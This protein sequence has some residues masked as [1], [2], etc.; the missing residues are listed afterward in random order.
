MKSDGS[1]SNG[2]D[3]EIARQKEL[4]RKEFPLNDAQCEDLLACLHE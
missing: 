4:A 2:R 1:S 3:A